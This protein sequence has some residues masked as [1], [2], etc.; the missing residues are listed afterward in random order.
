MRTFPAIRACVAAIAFGVVGSLIPSTA[1]SA[2]SGWLY[3]TG[4][5]TYFWGFAGNGDLQCASYRSQLAVSW[6]GTSI[7]A[8]APAQ[9]STWQYSCNGALALPA[10]WMV[11]A[12]HI[13]W[14]TD[15]IHWYTSYA[16]NA[17]N[18]AGTNHAGT[19]AG[20]TLYSN[21]CIKVGAGGNAL[22]LGG[23]HPWLYANG[24]FYGEGFAVGPGGTYGSCATV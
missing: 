23:W 20:L 3:D 18:A 9:T 19:T 22:I 13:Q 6:N 10:N 8:L 4:T 12:T 14:T 15:Y 16:P 7:G 11:V 24:G 1:A 21:G 17:N 5:T 2:G